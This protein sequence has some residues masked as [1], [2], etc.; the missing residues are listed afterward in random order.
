[1]NLGDHEATRAA[2]DECLRIHRQ[3]GNKAGVSTALFNLGLLAGYEGDFARAYLCY[4]EAQDIDR[5]LGNRITA[6]D[7]LNNMADLAVAQGD[8]T[9]AAAQF[10]EAAQIY[11]EHGAIGDTGYTSTGLGDVAF[12]RGDYGTARVYYNEA[13]ALFQQASNQRLVGRVLGQLGRVACREG[14][15]ATAAKL[16]GE[17]L[18]I[19]RSIGHRPGMLL[20]LDED[21]VELA[22]AAG[23]P[24]LA[25]RILGTVAHERR[26]MV[27]PRDPMED[28]QHEPLLARLR[29][30]LGDATLAA[31]WAEGE[32]ISLDDMVA[33]VLDALPV[34]TAA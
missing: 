27:R 31:A 1:M 28:K 23:Q 21:Y 9:R 20:I 30:Q 34:A 25:A 29:E 8:L 32:A 15:L 5:E 2:L 12:Y 11:R 7:G 22:L 17:A 13:L 18:S 16:C 6:A 10:E 14:D 4:Q 3:V 33:H 24:V 26:A 19:R